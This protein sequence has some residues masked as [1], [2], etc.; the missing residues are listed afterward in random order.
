MKNKTAVQIEL[1]DMGSKLAGIGNRMPFHVPIDYFE[2]KSENI[3][4][5]I[6]TMP[7]PYTKEEI[8]ALLHEIP[9][10][11]LPTE[12]KTSV[13]ATVNLLKQPA[14]V[15]KDE[16]ISEPINQIRRVS[17]WRWN[18][19]AAAAS[20][21]LLFSVTAILLFRKPQDIPTPVAT[22][23]LSI[24]SDTMILNSE[25]V[26]HFLKETDMIELFPAAFTD[27]PSQGAGDELLDLSEG[28]MYTLLTDVDDAA[29][30]E[31]IREQSIAID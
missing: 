29:I 10:T 22:T 17:G 21:V 20:I 16:N 11:N 27:L 6:A 8:T 24:P 23:Q 13:P 2:T 14:S 1:E 19:V 30:A 31:Y 25:E 15:K 9:F 5:R 3:A 7:N 4:S 26:D 12:K 18:E 28:N